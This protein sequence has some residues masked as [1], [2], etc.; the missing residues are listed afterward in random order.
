MTA[1]ADPVP[2][3]VIRPLKRAEYLKLA[4]TGAFEGERVELLYGRIEPRLRSMPWPASPNTG[5]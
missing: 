5:S 4:E 3:E 1:A 2:P